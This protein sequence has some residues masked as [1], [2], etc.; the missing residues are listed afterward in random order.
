MHPIVIA[1]GGLAALLLLKKANPTVATSAAAAQSYAT[2]TDVASAIARGVVAITKG[3][4]PGGVS[5]TPSS[6]AP[7]SAP[8]LSPAESAAAYTAYSTPPGWS[9]PEASTVTGVPVYSGDPYNPTGYVD[10]A[11]AAPVYDVSTDYSLNPFFASA[12]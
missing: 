6:L 4:T 10:A 11:V 5:T 1:A 12:P 9:G 8:Y 3:F 2:P 7:G